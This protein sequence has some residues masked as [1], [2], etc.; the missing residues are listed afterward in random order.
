MSIFRD[1]RQ[2]DHF[3]LAYNSIG[4][5]I[6]KPVHVLANHNYFIAMW[7]IYNEQ[8]V[9]FDYLLQ[10]L[11][12]FIICFFFGEIKCAPLEFERFGFIL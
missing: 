5:Q 2:R 8:D 1:D 10:S 7:R 9:T 6:S 4:I 3:G 12:I 11:G